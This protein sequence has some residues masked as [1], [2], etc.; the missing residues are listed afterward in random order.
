MRRPRIEL[1]L[2]LVAL[3]LALAAAHRW[4]SALPPLGIVTPPIGTTAIL[5]PSVRPESLD[6][7]V[8]LTIGNDP[9][10]LSGQPSSVPYV[11]STAPQT[12]A[13]PSAPPRPALS[14]KAIVG[15]PPW[16]AILDGIPGQASGTIVSGG[17][18]FDKLRV[19]SVS[20]DSVIV[21]G[22]DTVWKLT[23]ARSPQ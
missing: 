23:L 3:L 1:L 8:D 18:K 14:L 11:R 10:R 2:S 5:P 15:G 6:D 19:R 13:V 9:F 22:L 12:A 17:S 4:R 7:L 20:R 21:E 16:Q